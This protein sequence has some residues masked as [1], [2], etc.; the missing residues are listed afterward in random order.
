MTI[1]KKAAAAAAALRA[2]APRARTR[3]VEAETI[4]HAMR[5]HLKI[6]RRLRRTDPERIVRTRICGGHVPNG[7]KYSAGCDHVEIKGSRAS[8]LEV[9]VRRGYAQKRP[10]G[11]GSTLLVRSYIPG[12]SQGR[13]E[14][15]A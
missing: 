9:I 12:Q 8:D 2:E 13:V 6:A 4:E 14:V 1:A 11:I 7:Y 15:S 10:H 5:E 3:R